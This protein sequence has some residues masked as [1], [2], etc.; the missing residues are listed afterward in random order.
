MKWIMKSVPT[1]IIGA[2]V[3]D[4]NMCKI[5]LDLTPS[6]RQYSGGGLPGKRLHLQSKTMTLLSPQPE[7]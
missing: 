3:I 2:L 6:I 5:L 4:I 1:L 7:I